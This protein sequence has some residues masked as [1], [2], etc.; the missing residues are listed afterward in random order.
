MRI[1]FGPKRKK[2][3]GSGRKLHHEELYNLYTSPNVIRLIKTMRW[4]G[5]VACMEQ[6]KNSYRILL[7]KP[8]GKRLLGRPRYRW[9]DNIRMNLREIGWEGVDWKYLTQNK[10]QWQA[11]MNMIM[12]LQVP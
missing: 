5:H 8:K 6:M 1:I 12:N 11:L 2:V 4:T 10:D 3:A 9:E 7:R